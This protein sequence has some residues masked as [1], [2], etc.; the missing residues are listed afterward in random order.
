M[1]A[2]DKRPNE[3]LLSDLLPY[4]SFED[5]TG[6]LWLKDG[7]ASKMFTLTPKNCMSF[8]DEDLEVLRQNLSSVLGQVPENTFL[9]FFMVREKTNESSDHAYKNWIRTHE[10]QSEPQNEPNENLLKAKK[11][12]VNNLWKDEQLY[13][14]KVYVTVRVSPYEKSRTGAQTG[15]FAHIAFS[16][17]QKSK[18]KSAEQIRV[19]TAKA[20]DSLR[21]GVESVGFDTQELQKEAV[22]TFLF[23]F[24]NPDRAKISSEFS[25]KHDLSESIALSELI[26]SKKGLSIGRT[27]IRVATMKELPESSSPCLMTSLATLGNPFA[28]ILTILILPQTEEK[29]RLS[30]RQRLAQGMAAGN[31]VRNLYAESQLQDI[32]ETMS[33]MISSGDKLVATSFHAVVF[34]EVA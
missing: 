7:S 20:F 6:L 17:N 33:A 30:R 10:I 13:Q 11:A 24:L 31:N 2:I 27:Q 3:K 26:E 22:L 18:F 8:T 25:N 9:Q 28:L 1:N 21:S 16:K 12:N 5:S 15:A 32:E 34:D 4:L 23:R 19:E 14:T 29:E